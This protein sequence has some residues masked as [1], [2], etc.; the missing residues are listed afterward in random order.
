MNC[1]ISK[2]S[3]D[4][5]TNQRERDQASVNKAL[6]DTLLQAV[7]K[8]TPASAVHQSDSP[9]LPLFTGL[10][11]NGVNHALPISSSSPILKCGAGH[12]D[13]V[14]IDSS[15]FWFDNPAW[16]SEVQSMVR[17]AMST[18]DIALVRADSCF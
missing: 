7:A 3:V 18:L 2:K 11:V 6:A 13:V 4:G 12:H 9:S 5:P 8:R 10:T 14:S 15:E 16:Q 17:N 1:S